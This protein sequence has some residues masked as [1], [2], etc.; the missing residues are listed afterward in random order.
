MRVSIL[1]PFKFEGKIQA[2]ARTKRQ[3]RELK[4]H[5]QISFLLL[6][7]ANIQA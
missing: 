2:H 1:L 3:K 4:M 6:C 5:S 7:I